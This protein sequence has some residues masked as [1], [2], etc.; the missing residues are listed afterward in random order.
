MCRISKERKVTSKYLH[1]KRRFDEKKA[2]T[3][4]ES[5]IHDDDDDDAHTPPR[6]HRPHPSSPFSPSNERNQWSRRQRERGEHLPPPLFFPTRKNINER[7]RGKKTILIC[8]MFALMI[9]VYFYVMVNKLSDLFLY[10]NWTRSADEFNNNKTH[11][12][13]RMMLLLKI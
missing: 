6:Q 11:S 1:K 5:N 7:K 8:A 4:N 9:G 12:S 3:M 13:R 10:M 2:K